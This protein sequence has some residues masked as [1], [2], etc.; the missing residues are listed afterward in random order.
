MQTN[1]ASWEY[2]TVHVPGV[3][4]KKKKCGVANEQYF[5]NGAV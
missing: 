2:Y 3:S 1:K 5:T 4:K